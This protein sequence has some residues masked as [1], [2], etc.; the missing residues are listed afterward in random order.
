MRTFAI[1]FCAV[2]ISLATTTAHAGWELI[3]QSGVVT[4][5]NVIDDD[6]LAV[7]DVAIVLTG[8]GSYSEVSDLAVVLDGTSWAPI[9]FQTDYLSIGDWNNFAV[10]FVPCVTPPITVATVT[11]FCPGTSPC[12]Q[13]VLQP[14]P[15]FL[16]YNLYDCDKNP[17]AGYAY[18]HMTVNGIYDVPTGGMDPD[19]YCPSP[20]GTEESTWGKVKSLY[21]N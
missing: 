10:A 3:P 4:G 5:C 8:S 15:T 1:G 18:A 19:C 17:V 13:V 12:G 20:L 11:Y 7:C 6:A 9:A 21:R 14:S 16:Q 2:L